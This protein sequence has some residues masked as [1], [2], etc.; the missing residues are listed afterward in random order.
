MSLG[1]GVIENE[2]KQKNTKQQELS[3]KDPK[4]EGHRQ[5]AVRHNLDQL[6]KRFAKILQK[7]A[8]AGKL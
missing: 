7:A 2:M 5:K 3:L 8:K 6:H 4:Q 1:T